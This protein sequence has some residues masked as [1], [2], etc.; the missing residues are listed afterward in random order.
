MTNP[1]V[2]VEQ[3]REPTPPQIYVASLS[4]YNAG[5][6]HGEWIRADQPIEVIAEEVQQLLTSSPD[7][8][9]EET[10][11]HDYQGFFGWAPSEYEALDT[12]S[13]IGHGIHEHGPAF[14]HWA[15]YAGTGEDELDRFEEAFLGE[16]DSTVAYAESLAEDIGLKIEVTPGSWD[17]YVRFDSAALARDLEVEL[18][19]A[20]S[21]DGV[22]VFDPQVL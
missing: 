1:E 10:A 19:V 18:H 6:L 3:E 5:R 9:A 21:K 20:E 2:R 7:P 15:T 14:A 17:S 16:H 11:I 12:V 22:Y 4:D 8:L 13:R